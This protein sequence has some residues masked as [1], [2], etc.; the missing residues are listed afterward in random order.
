MLSDSA[1]PMLM[2]EEAQRRADALASLSPGLRSLV[3]ATISNDAAAD[4]PASSRAIKLRFGRQ[5]GTYLLLFFVEV[6]V[7]GLGLSSDML[8]S[9]TFTP[10]SISSTSD[11][12]GNVSNYTAAGNG[13]ASYS[14]FRYIESQPFIRTTRFAANASNATTA[15]VNVHN[16]D[17]FS[18]GCRCSVYSHIRTLTTAWMPD[19][20]GRFGYLPSA[21]SG[22]QVAVPMPACGALTLYRVAMLLLIVCVA[23]EALGALCMRFWLAMGDNLQLSRSTA[24]LLTASFTVSVLFNALTIASCLAV[25]ASLWLWVRDA[26]LPGQAV[27]GMAPVITTFALLV[28]AVYCVDLPLNYFAARGMLSRAKQQ[29]EAASTSPIR[30][31]SLLCCYK[32]SAAESSTEQ[33][34]S[35][36][37]VQQLSVAP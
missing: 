34:E 33:P 2:S 24:R 11:T 15:S 13:T 7:V 14:A 4:T 25:V 12:L 22:Q 26:Q 28:V 17:N 1:Q 6:L 30:F 37:P 31:E 35:L 18:F 21:D 9:A 10:L 32:E 16:V 36:L 29:G 20:D 8:H 27:Q 19:V 23:W 3:S 5:I